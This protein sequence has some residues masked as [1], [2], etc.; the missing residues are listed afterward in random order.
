[1]REIPPIP[2]ERVIEQ[3]EKPSI[4]YH[5]S[6]WQGIEEF[7]P[8]AESIRDPQEGPV[9]F[10]TPDRA[11]ALQFL[12]PGDD[13][14]SKRGYYNGIPTIIIRGSLGEFIK[15]DKGGWLYHLPS[16]AFDFDPK[17][18]M[19]DKEW[20]SRVPVKPI[21]SEHYPSTVDA[22]IDA[23][24]QVYFV[25]DALFTKICSEKNAGFETL[26]TL[27]SENMCRGKNIRKFQ[28]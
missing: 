19:R 9:I 22:L 24:V 6:E 15:R 12:V 7:E 4:L 23:G 20:T 26:L 5:A 2:T 25:D 3:R 13:R 27:T 18:S 14:E 21:E 16:G 11:Y 1:M 17:K 28:D 8:R 10:A